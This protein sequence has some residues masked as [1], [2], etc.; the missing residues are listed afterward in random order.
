MT[1]SSP[2]YQY[3]LVLF[4]ITGTAMVSCN[5][6]TKTEGASKKT[7]LA[8]VDKSTLLNIITNM[9]K[10]MQGK[11]YSIDA[12]KK[13]LITYTSTYKIRLNGMPRGGADS[14]DY[15]NVFVQDDDKVDPP[16]LSA[17]RFYLPKPLDSQLTFADLKKYY[18]DWIVIPT[19]EAAITIGTM[20]QFK[21]KPNVTIS[22]QSKK[23]PDA[24]DN[25]IEQLTVMR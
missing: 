25:S 11:D 9:A 13:L 23:M 15:L 19:P 4:C 5:Q 22:T 2:L 6:P 10:T 16:E 20:F 24:T 1:T 17:F 18:G 21:G 8:K 14:A 3:M 12:G 7:T